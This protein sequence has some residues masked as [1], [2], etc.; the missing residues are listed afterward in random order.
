MK[1]YTTSI[2]PRQPQSD[3]ASRWLAVARDVWQQIGIA[4]LTFTDLDLPLDASDE[5]IWRVCDA[6]DSVPATP[7]DV[8]AAEE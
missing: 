8:R 7:V 2:K 6:K 3:I 5:E 4:S 1:F